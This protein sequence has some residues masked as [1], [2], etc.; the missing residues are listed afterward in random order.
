MPIQVLTYTRGATI[1]S[2]VY[3]DAN[4]PIS[5][6]IRGHANTDLGLKFPICIS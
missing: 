6:F 2:P 3:L 4:F 1:V 5:C